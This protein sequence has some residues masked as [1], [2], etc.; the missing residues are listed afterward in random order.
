MGSPADRDRKSAGRRRHARPA[1]V[2]R[3]DR[4]SPAT[5]P[6][7]AC[8]QADGR[9]RAMVLARPRR[10]SRSR[11]A[12]IRPAPGRGAAPTILRASAS[13]RPRRRR[14]R[15][16]SRMPRHPIASARPEHRRAPAC[17]SGPCRRRRGD[18]GNWCAA[19]RSAGRGS[20]RSRR[21]HP[22]PDAA[23]CRRRADNARCGIR[24]RHGAY[25]PRHP[26]TARCAISRFARRQVRP[27]QCWP[28]PRRPRET[29]TAVA[30]LRRSA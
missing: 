20:C 19:A 27:R 11:S 29:T 2:P 30:A 18:A 8:R 4:R 3:R 17:S 28:A 23:A 12:A 15:P 13:S 26:A 6:A 5:D 10:F 14:H 21:W 1:C 24:R 9:R 16:R 7:R 22:R 25:R